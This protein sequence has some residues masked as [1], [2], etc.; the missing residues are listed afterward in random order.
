MKFELLDPEIK[1]FYTYQ[2]TIL[3]SLRLDYFIA[4]FLTAPIA[5]VVAW[6]FRTQ[7][8]QLPLDGNTVLAISFLFPG[9]YLI[10]VIL[11]FFFY[12]YKRNSHLVMTI[13]EDQISIGK[14]NF[15]PDSI[16]FIRVIGPHVMVIKLK[17]LSDYLIVSQDKLRNQSIL[18]RL[19]AIKPDLQIF[20][21]K[22][23]AKLITS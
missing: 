6:Y 2:K 18:E 15:S 12:S 10:T 1:D 21:D 3:R 14:E 13:N 17:G 22:M 23:G 16:H 19:V 4:C 9:C 8:H 20:L 7:V 11:N 5:A